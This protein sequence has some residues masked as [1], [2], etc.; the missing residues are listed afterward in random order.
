[1]LRPT[2]NQFKK[3]FWY[4]QNK[5]ERLC[6]CIAPAEVISGIGSGL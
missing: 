6:M 5:K 1:M 2:L 4:M 3:H